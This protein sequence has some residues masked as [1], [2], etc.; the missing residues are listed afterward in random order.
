MVVATQ[1][2]RR[3]TGFPRSEN[4]MGC[5]F[6][7]Q[8]TFLRYRDTQTHLREPP[9]PIHADVPCLT[10]PTPAGRYVHMLRP[11]DVGSHDV[12]AHL[13]AGLGLHRR[14]AVS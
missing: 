1:G 9:A 14:G 5:I 10:R 8:V 6:L 12:H 2:D 3:P 13:P 11:D 4:F 7:K